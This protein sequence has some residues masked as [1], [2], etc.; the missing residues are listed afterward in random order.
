M[1]MKK[2]VLATS[3]LVWHIRPA[4]PLETMWQSRPRLWI[5]RPPKLVD[6]SRPRLR[7]PVVQ[8][9]RAEALSGFRLAPPLHE[10]KRHP[11]KRR[12]SGVLARYALTFSGSYQGPSF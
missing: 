4:T 7:E 12:V 11:A 9:R 5:S 8:T 6:H 2:Q 10:K 1:S 3:K